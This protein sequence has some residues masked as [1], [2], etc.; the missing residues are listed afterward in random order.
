[1]QSIL[2]SSNTLLIITRGNNITQILSCMNKTTLIVLAAIA[3]STL[4][5]YADKNVK[6]T[7]AETEA[8]ALADTSRVYDID[9]VVIIDQPKESFRL[10]QQPLSSN[11]FSSYELKSLNVQ[12]LRQLSVFV[13]SFCMPEYGSRIT[14]SM[15]IR[16]IGSRINSPAV[17]IYVDG[18]PILSKSA[19]NFHT[20][21]LER[22]DI[23]HG[24][25]GTLYGMNTEGG[26][27][28]L[29]THNPFDYQGTDVNLSIG[30]RF[31]RKAEVSHYKKVSEK[32]AY[33]IAGFYDGQ[34]GFFRNQYDNSHADRFN[35]FGFRGRSLW[36]PTERLTFDLMA[37]YQFTGQN[38][39]PYGRYL[40]KNDLKDVDITSPL[41]HAKE[42]TQQPSQNR[43]SNYYRNMLNT[44]L[45]IKYSGNGF[46]INSMTTYQFLRD[47]M[48]MDIDYL[49]QD[50]MHM[51]QRQLQNSLSEELSIK[52]NNN[53][54]WHWTFGAF[55]SYQWLK[56]DAN[57]YFDPDM[58]SM[59]SKTIT[60]YAYN[61]MLN[62]MASRIAQKM[63]A[64]GMP[65]EQANT[66]ARIQAAAA[67][68]AAGGC[69]INMDMS[70]VPG[71][72][73]TP[74][75]NYGIYHES[76]IDITPHLMATLGLR[77][78]Y[79]KV[80]IDYIT[81]AS[82]KMN[83]NVMGTQL[84]PVIS[85]LLNHKESNHFDEFLP[86]VGLTYKFD[87]GSN[88][89]ATWSKGYR[90]GGY[91]IQM[92]SD[93]LQSELSAQAKTA[94]TDMNIQHDDA[95]YERIAK[96]IQ[97]KPERSWNY[98]LGTHLNLFNNQL[99]V[100]LAT[101][102][103]QIRNQQLSVMAGNYGFG[104]MMTNAGKSHST[105]MELT[106]R[107]AAMSN[108]LKYQLTYGFTSAEFDEYKDTTSAG[109][110]DYKNRHVP[111]V[112]QHTLAAAAD[113]T[114][115]INPNE[116][117]DPENCYRLRSATFGLNLFCQ[118]QTW[119]N[120]TNT[121][122]QRFYAV[123]GAHAAGDFGPLGINIWIR[124]LTETKYN[125]FA[126]QSS[127]TGSTQTF[128]QRGNPFQMG[129]DVS[130]HF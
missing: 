88:I 122:K 34:N 119:W 77:Y 59:L 68:Q 18:M 67:I 49:P 60:S 91:N 25:Q 9:E 75:F 106:V 32:Y 95:Y 92:F 96:T 128:A 117:L 58:N 21:G 83:E 50:Y 24:P 109:A 125:T 52:S 26:L 130:F 80:K 81:S 46:D 1:M 105:G 107:G 97:Y 87:N 45:G 76:N 127:A 72:F 28:R 14:S 40:T 79:S 66:M 70:Y 124:N 38:G 7:K 98:E 84:S 64:A 57:V 55:A 36:R 31:W 78:D 116:L 102:Y 15:Y 113:Y 61:G 53:S 126:V 29:Y 118:G 10:R 43:Q 4:P 35:E 90:S 30:S 19:F 37:D 33:S 27:V 8:E 103:M 41:Y 51:T 123:L 54:I 63:I 94:R 48:L 3:T 74:T 23:L 56:T 121:I 5:V 6:N 65:E 82:I 11:S 111:F 89:Y 100:D 2:Y 115:D 71:N 17:G 39:F 42:G 22:V 93:I 44:G 62:A 101:F 16:G 86:K 20:Y 73:H 114:I 129:V 85:S 47:R 108:K 99:H 110:V 120:E 69:N 13:P 112:P 104:R 12:D